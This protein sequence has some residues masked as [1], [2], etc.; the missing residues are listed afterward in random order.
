MLT[1][2][3]A[4]GDWA[5]MLIPAERTELGGIQIEV[6]QQ[7][8]RFCYGRLVAAGPGSEY[9]DLVGQIVAAPRGAAEVID[10]D[11]ALGK[12][13]LTKRLRSIPPGG[14]CMAFEDDRVATESAK[15]DLGG[16]DPAE[17][18]AALPVE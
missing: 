15:L 14:I 10:L 1:G 6:K 2:I 17:F 3:V 9:C 16:T 12:S 8:A 13:P 11:T 4:T 7:D 18:I 5:I